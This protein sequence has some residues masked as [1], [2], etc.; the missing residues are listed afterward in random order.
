MNAP[1]QII[2]T[3]LTHSGST[4]I[5]VSIVYCIYII[6]YFI[7]KMHRNVVDTKDKK[8]GQMQSENTTILLFNDVCGLNN[9]NKIIKYENLS[10][11]INGLI[12]AYA[13]TYINHAHLSNPQRLVANANYNM[14]K[15]S[16]KLSLTKT[17]ISVSQCRC[18]LS[19]CS[20][21][22]ILLCTV[23]KHTR[24]NW[25]LFIVSLPKRLELS[26][27]MRIKTFH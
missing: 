13:C 3:C 11:R 7:S 26:A 18:A 15:A 14:A 21:N 8:I 16:A 1:F 17:Y 23:S 5:M 24:S 2:G 20:K 6:V 12:C 10:H 27:N 9:R 22:S 4:I 19:F 25:S